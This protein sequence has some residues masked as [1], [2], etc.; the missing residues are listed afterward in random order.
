MRD[1]IYA[2]NGENDILQKIFFGLILESLLF[3]LVSPHLPPFQ[4]ATFIKIEG[5]PIRP[6]GVRDVWAFFQTRPQARWRPAGRLA[7]LFS[8]FSLN[9]GK[10]KVRALKLIKDVLISHLSFVINHRDINC[11][12][13][14]VKCD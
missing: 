13:L 7:A 8:Y 3:L 10:F 4:K 11:L 2:R 12:L 5:R 9:A 6:L 14:I 1:S